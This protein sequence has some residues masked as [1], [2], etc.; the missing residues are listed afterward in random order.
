MLMLATDDESTASRAVRIIASELL[1]FL[2]PPELGC[3]GRFAC[4]CRQWRAHLRASE[5][6]AA[7]CR[8]LRLAWGD[9]AIATAKVLAAA[10]AAECAV[11]ETDAAAPWREAYITCAVRPHAESTRLRREFHACLGGLLRQ[12]W[13]WH[14]RV[15]LYGGADGDVSGGSGGGSGGSVGGGSE[16]GTGGMR[17]TEIE[18]APLPVGA[19]QMFEQSLMLSFTAPELDSVYSANTMSLALTL[20][21]PPLRSG[22]AATPPLPLLLFT[23]LRCGGGVGS[24]TPHQ[25]SLLVFACEGYTPHHA[26]ELALM[27][28]SHELGLY[29]YR[30]E[31]FLHPMSQ[32][33]CAAARAGTAAATAA[34]TATAP[35]VLVAYAHA[36]EFMQAV[37]AV[38]SRWQGCDLR[39]PMRC[40]EGRMLAV[41]LDLHTFAGRRLGVVHALL[42]H[43]RAASS[44]RRSV[45]T[46][47]ASDNDDDGSSSGSSNSVEGSVEPSATHLA[48]F[49]VFDVAFPIAGGGAAGGGGRA[50]TAC[51][52]DC[53]LEVW[54]PSGDAGDSGAGMSERDGSGGYFDIPF[55]TN[56]ADIVT[57][58]N[59]FRL[60]FQR[61]GVG[62]GEMG[63][64]G[65]VRAVS[66]ELACAAAAS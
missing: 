49:V 34:A 45:W 28:Q 10:K 57:D 16:G 61:S 4:V 54:V 60:F 58:E 44:S 55:T 59:R 36:L 12:G 31:Q 42:R 3:W 32:R 43:N 63:V 6:A 52:A 47:A 15:T 35:T 38:G 18:I 40:E 14:L 22:D 48:D 19:V 7:W 30:D 64:G 17:K 1:D 41:R 29:V 5:P 13:V 50:A 65:R 26:D 25:G 8:A 33:P 37:G 56:V 9:E 20:H 46:A 53:G 62:G 2:L 24:V 27:T 23:R 51:M 21:A 39:A 66:L 11:A